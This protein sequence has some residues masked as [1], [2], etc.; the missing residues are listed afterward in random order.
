MS[1]KIDISNLTEEEVAQQT[2][3]YF[4]KAKKLGLKP[5][6]K[7]KLEKLV[8]MVTAKMAEDSEEN[9]PK[10]SN[11]K[12]GIETPQERRERLRRSANKLVRVIITNRNPNKKEWQ[13][14]ILTASNSVVGTV[15]KFIPFGKEVYVPQILLNMIEEREF[16]HFETK[17]DQRTGQQTRKARQVKEFGV[18]RLKG[19]SK[20]EL[21]ELAKKQALE[22]S[23]D[24]ED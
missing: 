22:G 20:K 23:I 11:K 24:K 12:E 5:H 2:E 21:E 13:G 10:K 18:E 3:I 7:A 8:E 19:L 9:L 17:R 16:Q 14:E 15:R 1:D 6:H 4:E